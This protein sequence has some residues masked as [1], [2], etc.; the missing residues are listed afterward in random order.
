MKI[1]MTL[2][3][4]YSTC[5]CWEKFCEMSGFDKYIINEGGGEG[6]IVEFSLEEAKK[7]GVVRKRVE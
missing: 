4:V 2:Q 5:D 7:Y 3:E 1:T 6:I